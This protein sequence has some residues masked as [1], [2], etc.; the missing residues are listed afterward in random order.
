MWDNPFVVPLYFMFPIHFKASLGTSSTREESKGIDDETSFNQRH[1]W[2]N[3]K[4]SRKPSRENSTHKMAVDS[5]RQ[6]DALQSCVNEFC[7]LRRI[8]H[9]KPPVAWFNDDLRYMRD[10]LAAVKVVCDASDDPLYKAVY[11]SMLTKP[12]IYG[13]WLTLNGTVPGFNTVNV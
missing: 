6:Q 9:R 12:K 2:R 13:G 1:W 3:K 8:T 10:K 7:P 4:H 11:N 5:V